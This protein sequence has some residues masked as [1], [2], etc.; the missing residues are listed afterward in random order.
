MKKMKAR[1]W[2]EVRIPYFDPP[3]GAPREWS[4]DFM[5]TAKRLVAGADTAARA[6]RYRTQLAAF[7]QRDKENGTYTLPKT[8]PGKEA[9]Q[10]LY[11]SFWRETEPD[12]LRALAALRN[13]GVEPSITQRV[14]E[15]FLGALRR[16]ALRLFDA[17]AGTDDLADQ[18][19]RRIV[20]ARAR[21]GFAFGDTG[22]VRDALKLVSAEAQQKRSR[23]K[24]KEKEMTP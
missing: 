10:D 2:L 8:S 1:G 21:L 17:A 16:T 11:E 20:D 22:D 19:A 18:D 6:L 7:G 9:Y 5:A 12:F 4:A 24:S 3:S 23:R 13:D 14:R 15:A